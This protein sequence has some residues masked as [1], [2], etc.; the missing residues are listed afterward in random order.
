MSLVDADV[1][2]VM[3]SSSVSCRWIS[4]ECGS[5][6]VLLSHS[7]TRHTKMLPTLGH[8]ITLYKDCNLTVP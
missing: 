7:Q 8:V 5:R 1:S 2:T 4:S 6:W 3:M